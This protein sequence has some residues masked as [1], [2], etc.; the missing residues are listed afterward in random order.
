MA[1]ILLSKPPLLHRAF[2]PVVISIATDDGGS[3]RSIIHICEPETY[4]ELASFNVMV[5]PNPV[6][7]DIQ[8]YVQSLFGK[9]DQSVSYVLTV[10]YSA[11]SDVYTAVRSAAKLGQG[12]DMFA[13]VGRPLTEAKKLMVYNGYP[14]SVSMLS[15]GSAS[16]SI[17][18]DSQ[19][20]AITLPKGV[21]NVPISCAD[22]ELLVPEVSAYWSDYYCQVVGRVSYT[23]LFTE[24]RQTQLSKVLSYA[25]Q[26][27]RVELTSIRADL[28]FT[29]FSVKDIP[30]WLSV[31]RI[32][33]SVTLVLEPN[34]GGE[35]N[36][37]LTITQA[38]S[39]NTLT[40]SVSQQVE[41]ELEVYLAYR[42]N[43]I[44]ENVLKDNTYIPAS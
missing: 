2:S 42:D 31:S 6:T 9:N 41:P 26:T 20:V 11:Y 34:M 16:A 29:D 22:S 24:S 27:L 28:P 19:T 33:S 35:R 18:R 25:G 10:N 5:S 38:E 4:N 43:G 36:A 40:L 15:D 32:G 21:S 13:Y 14:T 23:F 39:G 7:V 17:V 44:T 30:P 1:A 12:A 8:R 3:G 37:T